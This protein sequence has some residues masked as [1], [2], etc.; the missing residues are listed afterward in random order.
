MNNVFLAQ[1]ILFPGLILTVFFFMQDVLQPKERE[2][3][4]IYDDD[5]DDLY[6]VNRQSHQRMKDNGYKDLRGVT[7][8]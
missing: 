3:Y 1:V 5:K 2:E 4:V 6:V 8:Q 7:K